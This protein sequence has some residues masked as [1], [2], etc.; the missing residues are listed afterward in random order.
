VGVVIWASS[1]AK[2]LSIFFS[3]P[4]IFSGLILPFYRCKIKGFNYE[5]ILNGTILRVVARKNRQRMRFLRHL[6][7]IDRHC[8]RI[9]TFLFPGGKM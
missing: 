9:L 8:E 4:F 3:L 7:H 1:I 5:I 6:G 2:S